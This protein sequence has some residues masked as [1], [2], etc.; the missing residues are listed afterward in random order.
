MPLR[1]NKN[2][3]TSTQDNIVFGTQCE[4]KFELKTS[5]IRKGGHRS[6][7]V[8]RPSRTAPVLVGRIRQEIMYFKSDYSKW[9]NN[10]PVSNK[11]AG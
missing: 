3:L 7:G 6:E 11:A 4:T 9:V 10:R 2:H 5:E 8:T 1:K